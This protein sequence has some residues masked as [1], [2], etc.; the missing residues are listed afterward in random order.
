[1]TGILLTINQFVFGRK[2][3]WLILIL[4]FGIYTERLGAA[5]ECYLL[6]CL[7]V[8]ARN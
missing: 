5:S 1:M 2:E 4:C 3:S 6:G 7:D 8:K